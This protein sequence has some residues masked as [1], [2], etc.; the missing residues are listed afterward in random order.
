MEDRKEPVL[1]EV[2]GYWFIYEMTFKQ[3]VHNN[4][5]VTHGHAFPLLRLRIDKG[6][7]C[8]LRGTSKLTIIN[9]RIN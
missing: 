6:S 3:N 7:R 1:M 2:H 5:V 4:A 8:M 9:H